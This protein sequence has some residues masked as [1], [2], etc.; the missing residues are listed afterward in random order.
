MLKTYR[1]RFVQLNML[2]VGIVL[3]LTLTL[4]GVYLYHNA[5]TELKMTMEA[6]VRPLDAV[7]GLRN[8]ELFS[9]DSRKDGGFRVG[10]PPQGEPPE[11]GRF[12]GREPDSAA[13]RSINTVFYDSET[14]KITLLAE[15]P[16][17]AEDALPQVLEQV[18]SREE[19]FG[20]LKDHG[21]IYFRGA[22]Q[23][24]VALASTRY[25]WDSLKNVYLILALVFAAA[26]GLFWLISRRISLLAVQPLEE[27]MT[28]EKQFVADASHDLKTPLTIV[29]ANTGI[30]R[31]NPDSTI[32]QQSKWIDSTEQAVRRMQG[33]ID[34]MLTLSQ[35]DSRDASRPKQNVDF[36]SVLTRAELQMESLAYEKQVELECDIPEG[37][38]VSGWQDHLQRIAEDLMENAL[39]YEPSG[40]TIRVN[41]EKSR[42]QAV[43]T[44]RNLGSVISPE[45]LPHV[46]QRFYRSDKARSGSGGHGLGLAIV[47]R[48]AESMDGTVTAESAPAEGTTFRVTLPLAK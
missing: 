43:L 20:T 44:V 29:L 38:T 25:I 39:K 2:L 28:R 47:K 15:T 19:D 48:M 45:D 27:A 26:M 4:L 10:D 3:L 9:E 41:L 12:S 6:V 36:S 17:V 5:Y 32:A 33:L 40:G 42:H 1:K 16:V 46:F 11:D 21:L 22:G 8:G 14:Q 31:E 24:K 34:E 18:F 7:A 35:A 23:D 13:R 30:L 37:I